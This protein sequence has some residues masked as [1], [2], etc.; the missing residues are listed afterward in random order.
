MGCV[1][2]RMVPWSD[3]EVIEKYIVQ[4]TGTNYVRSFTVPIK[5]S[6]GKA[7]IALAKEVGACVTCS[8]Y[9]CL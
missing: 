4:S 1:N 6:V 9:F 2:G 3:R 8:Y 7:I 5:R